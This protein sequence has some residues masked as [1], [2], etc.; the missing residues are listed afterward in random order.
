MLRLVYIYVCMYVHITMRVRLKR[1]YLYA[2]VYVCPNVK[3]NRMKGCRRTDTITIA[4]KGCQLFPQIWN[5]FLL[6]YQWCAVTL[7][8]QL[9]VRIHIHCAKKTQLIAL[10]WQIVQVPISELKWCRKKSHITSLKLTKP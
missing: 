3:Q 6:L 5:C 2:R 8:H 7:L 9:Y 1:R 4:D 10:N